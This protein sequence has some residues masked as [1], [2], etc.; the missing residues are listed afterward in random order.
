MHVAKW[1]NSL[2][3]RL[4]KALVDRLGVRAASGSVL[5]HLRVYGADQIRLR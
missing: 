5:D 4:P 3:V 1:G 2:A